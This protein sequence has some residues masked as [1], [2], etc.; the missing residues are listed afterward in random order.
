MDSIGCA[1]GSFMADNWI[2]PTTSEIEEELDRIL[3][4]KVFAAAQRSQAFLRYVVQRSLTDAP[5][6]L[7]EFSI[8]M[9]VFARDHDYD[10]S[11]D[12]TV[13]VEAGR[14]R[15]RV[16]GDYDLGGLGGHVS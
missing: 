16:R 13:R 2:K 1:G 15:R 7:K 11:I 3:S 10:P 5:G 12:A 4:S 9:D 8:A 14:V 6:P